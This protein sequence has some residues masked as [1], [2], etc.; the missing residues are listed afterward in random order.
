MKLRTFLVAS[1]A[2]L[3]L[4]SICCGYVAGRL[5]AVAEDSYRLMIPGEDLAFF[6]RIAFRLP[7]VFCFLAALSAISAVLIARG[8]VG[9]T[10]ASVVVIC[11]FAAATVITFLMYCGQ[12][13]P[14]SQMDWRIGEP[15]GP[16]Q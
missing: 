10:S 15:A 4:W 7:G 2:C 13:L 1:L 8:R 5:S 12:L 16:A 3:A 9:D 14:L 11:L 6:T